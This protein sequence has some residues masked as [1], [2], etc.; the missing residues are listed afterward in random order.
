MRKHVLPPA[1]RGRPPKYG[2]PSR[3]MTLTLPEDV[4]ARLQAI[5]DDVGRAIVTLVERKS[6]G[7]AHRR[8][9]E[10]STFG[11][12]AVIVVTPVRALKRIKG[13]QLVPIGNGR[14]LISLVPPNTVPQLEISIRDVLADGAVSGAERTTLEDIAEILREVRVSREAVPKEHTIIVL[15]SRRQARPRYKRQL[16]RASRTART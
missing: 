15:E 16:A 3:V 14:C 6:P 9:A 5:D 11:N 8:P 13:V 2:R 4:V 1:V 12:H 10:I 7:T